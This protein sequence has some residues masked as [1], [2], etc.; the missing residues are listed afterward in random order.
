MTFK[1]E[2]KEINGMRSKAADSAAIEHVERIARP[3]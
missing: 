1:G 3:A 2:V